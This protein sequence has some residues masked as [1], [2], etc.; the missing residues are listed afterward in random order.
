MDPQVIRFSLLRQ[1]RG[2]RAHQEMGWLWII[3]E[4]AAV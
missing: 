4:I 1:T 2:K 3:I